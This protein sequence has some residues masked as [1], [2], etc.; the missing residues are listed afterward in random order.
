MKAS[1]SSESS[2][3][4]GLQRTLVLVADLLAGKEIDR[5]SA[6]RR[7]SLK[8][9][10]VD[11]QLRAIQKHVPG[12]VK[13][14]GRRRLTLRFDRGK[15]E[16]APPFPIAVAACLGA[17]LSTLFEGSSYENGIAAAFA[18]VVQRTRHRKI[19]RDIERKFFF[20][21]QGGEVSLPTN[22]SVLD[23]VIEGILKQKQCR[24]TYLTFDEAK[25]TTELVD[26]LSVAIYDH[27]LYIIGRSGLGVRCYRFSRIR[28]VE[29]IPK[30]FEYP[31]RTEFDPEQLF[32]SS[33]GVF[34]GTEFNVEDIRI[35]V[36]LKWKNYA[37]T[38]RWHRSQKVEITT[39]GVIISLHA[40]VCPELQQW[41]LGFGEDAEV[42]APSRLRGA[43]AARIV[44][45][46][47]IY[48]ERAEC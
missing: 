39:E 43:I 3:F 4:V 27:Q 9:A 38:H 32:G 33:F 29:V 25:E 1:S 16:D 46:A 17:S 10:A 47:Q 34:I 7:T 5:E 40:R 13:V 48:D 36:A 23:D 19:F 20:V 28:E 15:L 26:P 41:I 11:R 45:M 30:A 6:V 14:P 2:R 12:V 37:R 31:S 42:L 22:A 18:Y 8:P 21:R 24:M 44:K 35:R